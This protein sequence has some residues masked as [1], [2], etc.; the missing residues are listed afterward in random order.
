MNND[1]SHL[2]EK[3][4]KERKKN[5]KFSKSSGTLSGQLAKMK[6]SRGY[7]KKKNY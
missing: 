5:K 4:R 2:E 6:V 3:L 1:Y 7:V